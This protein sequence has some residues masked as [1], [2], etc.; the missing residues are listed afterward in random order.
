ME[1]SCRTSYSEQEQESNDLELTK[2]YK[3]SAPALE[4]GCSQETPQ[5]TLE[6]TFKLSVQIFL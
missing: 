3:L 2:A 5:G 4:G 1:G 6:R